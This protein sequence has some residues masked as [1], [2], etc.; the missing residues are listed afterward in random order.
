[1]GAYLGA[2]IGR[3]LAHQ[4]EQRQIM[5]DQ[6][7][8]VIASRIKNPMD[9]SFDDDQV[10]EAIDTAADM[11]FI[12]DKAAFAMRYKMKAAKKA[13]EEAA[14][15]Q[16]LQQVQQGN[17]QQLQQAQQQ[18]NR[19]VPNMNPQVPQFPAPPEQ[20]QQSSGPDAS[21]MLRRLAPMLPEMK[22]QGQQDSP[23]PGQSPFGNGASAGAPQAA[24]NPAVSAM[25]IS[26]EASTKGFGGPPPVAAPAP[27]MAPQAAPGMGA[28]V[29]VKPAYRP[30]FLGRD[31]DEAAA[32]KGRLDAAVALPGE[33]QKNR[34]ALEL[35]K[36]KQQQEYE[37]RKAIFSNEPWF[38]QLSE[39][40]QA[41]VLSGQ[42]ISPGMHFNEAGM[43]WSEE[44]DVDR[45]GNPIPVGTPG[46]R[47]NVNGKWFFAPAASTLS[48]QTRTNADGSVTSTPV[49]R[50][51]GD[52]VQPPGSPAPGSPNFHGP[53]NVRDLKGVN[54]AMMPHFT[55]TTNNREAL[56]VIGGNSVVIPVT[57]RSRV[58]RGVV[59][60][61]NPQATPGAAT[62]G[63][64]TPGATPP[65]R[66]LPGPPSAG[67]GTTPNVAPDGTVLPQGVRYLG[68]T[69]AEHKMDVENPY[70]PN[71]QEAM[72]IL[73]PKLKMVR[74]LKKELEKFKNDAT[75]ATTMLPMLAYKLGFGTDQTR[76]LADLNLSSLNQ[77]AAVTGGM[78]RSQKV[79][80]EG[81]LHV[82]EAWKDS[83]KSMYQKVSGI[84]K[85]MEDQEKAI[86]EFQTKNPGR[87][88]P[89][90]LPAQPGAAQAPAPE[91]P[92]GTAEHFV[93]MIKQGLLSQPQQ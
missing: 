76:F 56:G 83:K 52:V 87:Y 29:P 42:N 15:Q 36:K 35:E 84:L 69:A 68:P 7:L 25:K 13:K 67:A 2:L 9:T 48:F 31:P 24:P 90:G 18:D 47:T 21:A 32:M 70:T 75:P 92:K 59:G 27:G 51:T 39:R 1:M 38:N 16:A 19:G 86:K 50:Y 71:G 30:F 17:L 34:L 20:S 65:T 60:A 79:F 12:N 88:K 3:H 49:N 8:P 74:S 46:R 37:V 57:N 58:T 4:E 33:E 28:A 43:T 93:W 89:N 10:M 45:N 61:G 91:P 6:T 53:V 72:R 23:P 80:E 41:I 54:P 22:M 73:N 5:M 66:R 63:A 14:K 77:V 44:G 82:P 64:T 78:S 11:G 81:K 40:E 26:S 55:D 85:F 62:P